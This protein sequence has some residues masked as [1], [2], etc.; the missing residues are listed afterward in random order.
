MGGVGHAV[1]GNRIVF[2]HGHQCVRYLSGFSLLELL[3]VVAIVGILASIAYPSF[4]SHASRSIMIDARLALQA[5]AA[6]QEQNR[7]KHG[8]Y[9]SLVELRSRW[10]LKQRLQQRFTADQALR[11]D[12]LGFRL[13]LEPRTPDRVLQPLSLDHLGQWVAMNNG[14]SVAKN[15]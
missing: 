15:R 14:E 5:W 7:L 4:Q 12:G 6:V 9:L 11:G 2:E 3:V 13:S 1:Y 8:R 10:P